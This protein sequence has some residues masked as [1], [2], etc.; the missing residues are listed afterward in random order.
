MAPPLCRQWDDLAGVLTAADLNGG[1]DF[2]SLLE[3][4][5][6]KCF[7]FHTFQEEKPLAAKYRKAKLFV[8][9][10]MMILYVNRPKYAKIAE[11]RTFTKK[12]NP[13]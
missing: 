2:V 1:K 8:F 4:I 3:R 6:G 11:N 5:H 7:Y 10:R 13:A 12:K 9:V